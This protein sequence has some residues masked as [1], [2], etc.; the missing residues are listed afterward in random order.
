[1][2]TS[3]LWMG[4]VLAYSGVVLCLAACA[5]SDDDPKELVAGDEA[6]VQSAPVDVHFTVATTALVGPVAKAQRATG[7]LLVPRRSPN[8]DDSIVTAPNGIK[9]RSTCGVTFIDRTH[10]ITAAH[11][12]DPIDI[13]NPPVR[14][15][16]VEMYDVDPDLDWREAA[17]VVGM[18]PNYSHARLAGK[19]G[20]R[21]TQLQCVTQSRCAFG[22][23]ECPE[24]ALSDEADIAL[25]KCD[26]LPADR[27]P[28]RVAETDAQTSGPVSVFWFHEIYN[29]PT[30]QPSRTQREALDL[31]TH[32]TRS[33]PTGANNLHYFDDGQNDLLP[34]ISTDWRTGRKRSRLGAEGTVVWTDLF[35]CHG[36]SGSGVMAL[37]PETNDFVLLGP[38]ATG[39]MDWVTQRLCA[40]V[41]SHREGRR[42]TSYTML[43][44]TQAM[45]A[46][47][48]RSTTTP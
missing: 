12:T 17:R 23:W 36:T 20:Y 13:P 18:Y 4:R 27:E 16:T 11:C 15:M 48:A 42:S 30:T 34:L 47:A 37:D 33:D 26:P 39:S 7:A 5:A 28:V 40:N 6:A 45:A 43:K 21:V 44:Y 1:M 31:Y 3:F 22:T 10:A 24:P 19:P 46:L 29:A 41:T 9:I 2:L 38:V 25:L 32:Y 35:G 14:P 8:G